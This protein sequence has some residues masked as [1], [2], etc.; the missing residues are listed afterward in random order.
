VVHGTL[1]ALGHDHP[2]GAERT[3]SVMWRRQERYVEA[4]A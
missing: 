2:E 1:H 4:L 3:R